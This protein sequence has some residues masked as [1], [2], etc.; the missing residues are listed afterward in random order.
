MCID[1]SSLYDGELS[2]LCEQMERMKGEKRILWES[3]ATLK[4][5][6]VNWKFLDFD[7]VNIFWLMKL[8][9]NHISQN[10]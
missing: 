3:M 10:P 5:C 8:Y 1:V 7:I 6:V 4:C 2:H 9:V